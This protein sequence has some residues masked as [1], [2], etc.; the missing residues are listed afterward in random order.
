MSILRVFRANRLAII[1]GSSLLCLV[2]LVAGCDSGDSGN[3]PAAKE[4]IKVKQQDEAAARKK[5]FG[6]TAVPAKGSTSK[7]KS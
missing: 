5:A 3:S 2:G 4:D 1:L 7:P 6:N